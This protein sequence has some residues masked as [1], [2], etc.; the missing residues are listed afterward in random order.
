MDIILNDEEITLLEAAV[1]GFTDQITSLPNI[2]TEEEIADNGIQ[3]QNETE[4]QAQT[5]WV[6]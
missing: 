2:L 3:F 5:G 6:F 4:S 1:P